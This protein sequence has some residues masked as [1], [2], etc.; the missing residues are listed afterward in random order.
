ML[1]RTLLPQ[2]SRSCILLPLLFQQMNTGSTSR[3]SRYQSASQF[4][5]GSNATLLV[6]GDTVSGCKLVLLDRARNKTCC[7]SAPE[8]EETMCEP[9]IQSR[10]C[11][12]KDKVKVEE[13]PG[14]C[15]ITFSKINQ[16]DAGPYLVIFPGRVND[17]KQFE[18]EV[19]ENNDKR[20]L[21][22]IPPASDISRYEEVMDFF[23]GTTAIVSVLGNTGSGC[24]FLLMDQA[25]NLTCC[26]SASSR[27]DT[28]CHPDTQSIACRTKERYTDSF[29]NP[30]QSLLTPISTQVQGG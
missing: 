3:L 12:S 17:N 2:L 1:F 18:V 9:A 21:S 14:Y 19:E 29:E 10:G 22:G 20:T 6:K 15:K 7:Y 11:R 27:G 28:L 8:R 25:R 24:K 16:E 4:S 30:F 13:H 23:P 5:P 26:F